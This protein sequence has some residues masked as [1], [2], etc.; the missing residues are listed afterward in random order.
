VFVTCCQVA[1]IP[2]RMTFH[3]TADGRAGH[4]LAEAR[5]GRRWLLFD[6]DINVHGASVPGAHAS[7]LDLMTKGPVAAKFDSL[8]S[9][10]MLAVIGHVRGGAK[11][12]DLF[13]VVGICNYPVED[14]PYKS[15]VATSRGR[16]D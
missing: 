14:F 16:Y 6:S 3:W 5:I 11:Y 1:G 12:S 4:S 9:R 2:A 10:E 7:C 8:V 13:K 15:R